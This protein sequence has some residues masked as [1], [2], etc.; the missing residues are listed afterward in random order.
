MSRQF[1]TFLGIGLAVVAVALVSVLWVNKGSHLELKG[2]ILKVRTLSVEPNATILAIDFRVT[3]LADYVYMIKEAE[4][5]MDTNDGKTLDATT[6]S[7][8]DT[9]RVF[10]FYKVLG[11]KYNQTLIQRDKIGPRET[12]D[13]ML[14][15]RVE[16]PLAAV[17]GRKDLHLK[18]DEADG[19]V[20]EIKEHQ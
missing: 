4:V 3:N 2:K 14:A 19:A 12:A 9:D 20:S 15:V 18:L 11:P 7:R 17:D 10:E 16:A 13:R 1:W 5:T 8:D 6:I